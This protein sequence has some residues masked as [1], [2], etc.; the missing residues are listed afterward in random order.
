MAGWSVDAE[1]IIEE[2]KVIEKDEKR[3]SGGR[4]N[5]VKID[6]QNMEDDRM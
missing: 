6:L 5:T 2:R 4:L 3:R 1:I